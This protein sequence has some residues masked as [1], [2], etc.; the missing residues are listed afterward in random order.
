MEQIGLAEIYQGDSR[1][2]L[3]PVLND[4]YCVIT[5]PV[6]PNAPKGMFD[7]DEDAFDVLK[8]VLLKHTEARRV[9]LVLRMD[10]DPRFLAAVP[11]RWPFFRAC[12]LP[13]ASPGYIGRKLGGLELAYVFGDPIPSR[14]GQR[15]IPGEAPKA[16]PGGTNKAHPC[17]RNIDHMRWL[18]RWFSE[19]DE[20]VF[21]PFMGS[22]TIGAAAVERGR[23]FVGIEIDPDYYAA[24]R[25]SITQ[26]QQQQ[27]LF[28]T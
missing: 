12:C 24:G 16:Q 28:V 27:K 3:P 6:W 23:R 13:Y 5:D 11:D 21:D 18:V 15:V 4:P 20:V 14:E 17:A 10:S 25:E 8:K 2:I 26:A 9:V 22:G 7:L 19:P 1:K